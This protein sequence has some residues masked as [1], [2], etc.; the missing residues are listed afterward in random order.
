MTSSG[1]CGGTLSCCRAG[2]VELRRGCSLIKLRR[3]RVVFWAAKVT[4][5][6]EILYLRGRNFTEEIS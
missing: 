1:F 3:Q 4:R 2:W 5:I 6:C